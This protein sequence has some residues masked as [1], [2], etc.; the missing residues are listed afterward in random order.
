SDLNQAV[1]YTDDLGTR[2]ELAEIPAEVADEVAAARE[3]MIEAIVE[4][5]EELMEKYLEGEEI[6][7]EEL[8][9][10]LR[11]A[12]LASRAVPVLCGSSFK[13]KG[14]QLLLDAIVDYLPSPLDLPPVRGIDPRSEEHTSELQSRE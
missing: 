2:T 3:K 5:D 1:V 13:N 9:R 8:K 10:G 11:K 12:C 7:P 4:H 6:T 14:V